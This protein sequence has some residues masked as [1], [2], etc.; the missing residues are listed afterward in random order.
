MSCVLR[1][2]HTS[3]RTVKS[4]LGFV[5]PEA[6]T[7]PG[8]GRHLPGPQGV[9]RGRR[10]PGAARA[11]IWGTR[12]G[13]VPA[14]ALAQATWIFGQPATQAGT[15]TPDGNPQGHQSSDNIQ[16]HHT[17]PRPPKE[18]GPLPSCR[19]QWRNKHL[20][21]LRSDSFPARPASL[22]CRFPAC[23]GRVRPLE[24]SGTRLPHPCV[25]E[26]FQKLV[27]AVFSDVCQRRRRSGVA[28]GSVNA[29]PQPRGRPDRG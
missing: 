1:H 18:A 3:A 6:E 17:A 2:G 25:R 8:E 14:A 12:P 15:Q 11:W 26:L 7:S 22:G 9:T 23:R 13:A 16:G 5:G 10:G 4:T 24:P 19:E 21:I 20:S 27:G 29:H 28:P